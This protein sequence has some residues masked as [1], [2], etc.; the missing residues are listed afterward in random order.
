MKFGD[1]EISYFK[2]FKYVWRRFFEYLK[3]FNDWRCICCRRGEINFP[4]EPIVKV[5][6]PIGEA[7]IIETALLNM[8]NHQSL[9]ATVACRIK[10]SAGDDSNG[11]WD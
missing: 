11:V 5:I 6:A 3:N 4:W 1:K 7:Q 9:I 2:I 8:I 10:L